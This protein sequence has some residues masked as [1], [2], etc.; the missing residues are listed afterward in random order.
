V[1][2]LLKG[3]EQ[4]KTLMVNGP[5]G[6]KVEFGM[7]TQI[8]SGVK[9][10]SR[11]FE[12]TFEFGASDIPSNENVLNFEMFMA[13]GLDKAKRLNAVQEHERQLT[14]KQEAYVADQADMDRNLK[15]HLH[16]VIFQ[17]PRPGVRVFFVGQTNSTS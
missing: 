17:T 4:A 1:D 9:P 16:V 15:H 7:R 13:P 11:L 3:V 5:D 8:Y 12:N 10:M 6:D 2:I 14:A